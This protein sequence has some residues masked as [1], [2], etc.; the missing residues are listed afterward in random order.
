MNNNDKK[1]KTI[2]NYILVSDNYKKGFICVNI[3]FDRI[4]KDNQENDFNFKYNINTIYKN[5]K[6]I[7]CFKKIIH[8]IY[9]ECLLC[10]GDNSN[11]DLWINK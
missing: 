8:P 1:I 9:G 2:N 3:T 10:S 5:G 7:K 4:I 6:N 11:I